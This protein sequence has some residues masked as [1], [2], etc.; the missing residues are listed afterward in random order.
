MNNIWFTS[1]LHFWHYNP[2]TGRGILEFRRDTRLG[3]NIEE[4]NE[5]LI[6]NWNQDIKKGDI[7]YNLGDFSFG[8]KQQTE[9]ILK[10]L[11]GQHHIIL[12]NHDS[13]LKNFKQ[14]F[15][16]YNQYKE[17][18]KKIMG[19]PVC[20][21]HFPIESWHKKEHGSLHLYGHMHGQSYNPDRGEMKAIARRMD[22]GIDTRTDMRPWN[23]EEIKEKLL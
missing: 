8:S 5:I 9:E 13:V 19:V 20:L 6:Q 12:G 1:D 18:S 21:F 22:V 15:A 11:N 17:L 4:M 2:K 16:S 3:D 23:W 7:V 14:Y 10:R